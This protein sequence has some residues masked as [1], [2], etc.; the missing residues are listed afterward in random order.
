MR[1]VAKGVMIDENKHTTHFG[2]RE[3]RE[4][5]KA[6]LVQDVFSSVA[7]RY[8]LMNDLMSGGIHRL[9]KD[10]M[11]DWQ[12]P[13]SHQRLLDV[14]GGTGDIALRFLK[15]A[16]GASA[17]VVDFTEP[18]LDEGRKRAERSGLSDRVE[19]VAGDAMSLP[20]PDSDFDVCTISFGIRNVTRIGDAL[21]EA[22]RVLRPGGRLM[23]L[24]FSHVTVP[25]LAR[26]LRFLLLRRNPPLGPG[27]HRRQG[28]LSVPGRIDP[29][30]SGPGLICRDDPPGRV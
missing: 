28:Q 30:I 22:F 3:V 10:A 1:L 14:A 21:A 6:G 4:D 27:G 29:S 7:S 8:D 15:R 19:W 2:A 24:E 18:M 20:F 13:R 11:L 9:W 17:V 12:A 16:N 23:V 5:E 26:N 25:A